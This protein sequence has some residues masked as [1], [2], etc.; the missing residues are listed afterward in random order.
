MILSTDNQTT[1]RES[2][3]C[4]C[5]PSQILFHQLHPV[6]LGRTFIKKPDVVH[7]NN[8]VVKTPLLPSNNHTADLKLSGTE[9]SFSYW[10]LYALTN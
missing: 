4:R 10:K 9:L 8:V 5:Q 2:M 1:Q 6:T 3:I 7:A